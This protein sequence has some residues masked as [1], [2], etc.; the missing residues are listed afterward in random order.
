MVTFRRVPYA[1]AFERGTRQRALLGALCHGK[2]TL[3]EV[4]F[5]EADRLVVERFSPL[6]PGD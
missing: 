2:S 5:A 3:A 4:D 6:A 1:V